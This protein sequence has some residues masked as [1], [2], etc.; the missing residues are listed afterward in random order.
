MDHTPGQAPCPGVVAPTETTDLMV[1]DFLSVCFLF[2]CFVLIFSVLL[3]LLFVCFLFLRKSMNREVR[4]IIEELR[5]EDK[6]DKKY[7]DK[8]SSGLNQ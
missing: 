4:S 5:R 8:N 7:F 6:Y 2:L 1:L 3:V